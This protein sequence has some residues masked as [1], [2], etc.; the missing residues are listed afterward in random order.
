[1]SLPPHQPTQDRPLGS[2]LR[3]RGFDASGGDG[4]D[5]RVLDLGAEPDMAAVG[6]R[7]ANAI[8]YAV[9]GGELRDK[10]RD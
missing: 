5:D 10:A 4:Q 3:E 7:I 9:H 2:Q 8:W 6:L 1:M